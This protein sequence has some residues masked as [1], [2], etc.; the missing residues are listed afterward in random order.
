MGVTETLCR[1]AAETVYDDIPK[2]AVEIAKERILETVGVTLAGAQ[3]T[4]GAGKK[5]IELVREMGGAPNSTVIGSNFKT[6]SPSAAFANGTSAMT[7]DLDDTIIEPT[8]HPSASFI[9]AV[10]ALGEETKASGKMVLE[11]YAMGKKLLPR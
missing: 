1:Y 6:S 5:V 7:L 4:C 11:A 3:E 10:L 2:E 8:N 9:P